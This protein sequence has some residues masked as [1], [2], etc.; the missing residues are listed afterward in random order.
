M[1]TKNGSRFS[2]RR[3]FLY[4]LSFPTSTAFELGIPLTRSDPPA[5]T[6]IGVR[7]PGQ[8]I[9]YRM[10]RFKAFADNLR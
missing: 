6:E 1:A 3:R 5:G 8:A 4:L 10:A 7:E 2:S 9:R